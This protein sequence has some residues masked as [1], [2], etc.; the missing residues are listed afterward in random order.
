MINHGSKLDSLKC[1]TRSTS[2]WSDIPLYDLQIEGSF[3]NNSDRLTKNS[4]ILEEGRVYNLLIIVMNL[5]LWL[6][7]QLLKLKHRSFLSSYLLELSRLLTTS[8]F[9]LLL[10]PLLPWM[11]GSMYSI[12]PVT[13]RGIYIIFLRSMIRI[14]PG[15]IMNVK[16]Q[17]RSM[18][19]SF[20][21]AK[22]DDIF[23]RPSI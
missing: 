23:M 1:I 2:D 15:L 4:P 20:K 8:H 3:L 14:F 17:C 10:L 21:T 7:H 19:L 9:H 18:S 13:S 22:Y 16:A 12:G 6:D 11:L 5:K